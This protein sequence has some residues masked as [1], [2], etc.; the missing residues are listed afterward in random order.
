MAMLH[1]KLPPRV[2]YYIGLLLFISE[3]GGVLGGRFAAIAVL[4]TAFD[5]RTGR[6]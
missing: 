4:L 3:Y 5:I 1:R 6:K 2:V